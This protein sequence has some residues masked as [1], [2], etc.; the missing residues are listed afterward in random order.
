MIAD[1]N[2]FPTGACSLPVSCYHSQSC[3]L[4]LHVC[5]GQRQYD[6]QHGTYG[7]GIAGSQAPIVY[8]TLVYLLQTMNSKVQALAAALETLQMQLTHPFILFTTSMYLR[9]SMHH[10]YLIKRQA[11]E[12]GKLHRALPW[13]PGQ[14]PLSSPM[15][16]SSQ[17]L[18]CHLGWVKAALV[19]Q[20]HSPG[21]RTSPGARQMET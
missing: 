1:G 15:N 7:T 3:E 5:F 2:H 17:I 4:H 10:P 8:I 14:Q 13:H 12:A 18:V 21:L 11:Q 9:A 16:P 19:L 6:E 20:Q